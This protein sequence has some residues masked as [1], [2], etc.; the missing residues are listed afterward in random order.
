M[1][2]NSSLAFQA[3]TAH[4]STHPAGTP[5]PNLFFIYLV[6]VYVLSKPRT[7]YTQR[8]LELEGNDSCITL[9]DDP[10]MSCGLVTRPPGHS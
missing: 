6:L 4:C 7:F 10:M 3:A 8:P 1:Q 5:P 9:G 2:T